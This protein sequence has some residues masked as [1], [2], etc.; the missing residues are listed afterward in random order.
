MV[1]R[2]KPI[3]VADAIEKVMAWKRRGNVEWISIDECDGRFLAKPLTADHDVPPFDRSPYD[4]FAIRSQDTVH[5]SRENP[6]VFEVVDEIGAGQVST[7]HLQAFQAIRIMT[8]ADI[9][10][11]ADS[12]IMLE[13]VKEEKKENKQTITIKRKVKH[14]ENISFQGEDAKKGDILIEAGTVINPGVKAL[15]A[16]FGYHQV[17][18]SKKPIIGVIATGSE[19]LKVNEPLEPGK[20]RNS[21]GYMIESQ[22]FRAGAVSR[23]FENCADDVES[24]LEA[25]KLAMKECDIIITTGGVSVGDFDH[26]PEIYKQIGAN[27]LF[28]KIAMRPGSVTTVATKEGKLF[29]GL[30]GNPS[31]CYVGFELFV[32]P[33]VRYW[34]HSDKPH[35]RKASAILKADF[36]KPNPFNRFVRSK[37]EYENGQVFVQP[38]GLDKSNVVTSVAWADCLMVLPGGTRGYKT[39]DFLDILLLEDQIGSG[40]PWKE[41][42]KSSK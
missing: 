34:M 3:W 28:N 1:E 39:G 19:L 42:R 25:V 36:P 37:L 29:Y 18:V 4:G 23:K 17:P 11:G 12:V 31:A 26:L 38:V 32:R 27:V 33:I 35:L 41:E 6:I 7:K 15:L 8:G 20:I 9:P 5:A 40:E 30:S 14:G 16:T 13:L 24:L 10:M 2:R 21:N 22:I